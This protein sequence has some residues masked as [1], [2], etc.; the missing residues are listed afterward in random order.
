L[1]D[2]NHV[3]GMYSVDHFLVPLGSA[4]R[5]LVGQ[6]RY[7]YGLFSHRRDGVWKGMLT[8]ELM[9]PSEDATASQLLRTLS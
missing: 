4:P 2:R 8:V 7:W 9:D 5:L 1:R 6:S 3:K